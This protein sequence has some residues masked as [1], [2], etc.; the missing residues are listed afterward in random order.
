MAEEPTHHV[1]NFDRHLTTGSGSKKGDGRYALRQPDQ[2]VITTGASQLAT[3]PLE[4]SSYAFTSQQDEG[5]S[6]VEWC[7]PLV[8]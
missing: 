1:W 8:K 7:K 5:K 6:S 2:I 3:A 4:S